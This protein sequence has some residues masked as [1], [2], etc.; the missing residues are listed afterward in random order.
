MIFAGNFLVF[1]GEFH[2]QA[3]VISVVTN[4]KFDR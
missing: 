3:P 2:T 4:G 1:D